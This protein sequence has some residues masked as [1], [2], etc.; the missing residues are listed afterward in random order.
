MPD[1]DSIDGSDIG[2]EDEEV[3]EEEDEGDENWEDAEEDWESE[4]DLDSVLDGEGNGAVQYAWQD[5]ADRTRMLV[6]LR[7]SIPSFFLSIS[8]LALPP[9]IPLFH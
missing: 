4:H 3:V 1:R 7:A 2:E 9:S 8:A 6:N 5:W